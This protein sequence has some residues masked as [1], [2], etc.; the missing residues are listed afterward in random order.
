MVILLIILFLT[1]SAMENL[2]GN[3]AKFAVRFVLTRTTMIIP[4]H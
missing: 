2:L 3:H 4:N 1:P